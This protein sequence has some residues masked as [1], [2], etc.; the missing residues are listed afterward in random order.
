M[1]EKFGFLYSTRF[2]AMVVA[3]V[4]LYLKTKGIFGD[5]EMML[6]ATI[7]GGFT[8][9]KTLDRGTEVLSNRSLPVDDK[10]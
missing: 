5:A 1:N 4:S 3:A 8:I 10:K 6:I 9:V 7:T 2:W